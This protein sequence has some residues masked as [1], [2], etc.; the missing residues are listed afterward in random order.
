MIRE[1][2]KQK[3]KTTVRRNGKPLRIL[4]AALLFTGCAS[5]D[6]LAAARRSYARH[7]PSAASI[8]PKKKSRK[9]SNRTGATPRPKCTEDTK[10]IDTDL[11][12]TYKGGT[13]LY[14]GGGI[15]ES[16][17]ARLVISSS[18]PTQRTFTLTAGGQTFEGVVTARTTCGY[19]GVALRFRTPQ[20][21][22]TIS[23][24]ACKRGGT[25]TLTNIA[26]Q[27]PFHFEGRGDSPKAPSKWGQGRECRR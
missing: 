12:G 24:F 22:T 7:T 16:S 13:L 15:A 4:L 5:L 11:S 21:G 26:G 14:P 3:E 6:A 8:K 19:T 17:S 1:F 27:Q 20:E 2:G 25:F 9:S 23:L 18:S 10:S